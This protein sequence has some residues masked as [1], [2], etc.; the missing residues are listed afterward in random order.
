MNYSFNALIRFLDSVAAGEIQRER[1]AIV[2]RFAQ[3]IRYRVK[4]KYRTYSSEPSDTER[5]AI[6]SGKA[7]GAVRVARQPRAPINIFEMLSRSVVL[8]PVG[9]EH[10]RVEIDPAAVHPDPS[11]PRPDGRSYPGGVPLGLLAYWMEYPKPIVIR[12][13]L[14]QLGYL[15][16]V[17][18]GRAG[19]GRAKGRPH[20]PDSKTTHWYVT[21][22][23]QRPVWQAV[24]REILNL[25]KQ[26][27]EAPFFAVL[28]RAGLAY[29]LRPF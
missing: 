1:K 15:Y 17:R 22:A 20:L 5:A 24:N 29:G 25:I 16:A 26:S 13:T 10:F 3:T 28:K 12:M 14:R 18:E 2:R 11:G 27:V 19:P 9:S 6:S 7:A 8:T 4:Q 23:P 21:Q